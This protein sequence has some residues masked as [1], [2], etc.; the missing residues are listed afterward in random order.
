MFDKFEK[1]DAL[2]EKYNE[3]VE[4]DNYQ[5][6]SDGSDA[7]KAARK[8]ML[9]SSCCR[10][11]FVDDV[12]P[13]DKYTFGFI[14]RSDTGRTKLS[15]RPELVALTSDTTA[16]KDINLLPAEVRHLQVRFLDNLERWKRGDINTFSEA[17]PEGCV[18]YELD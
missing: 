13:W 7:Q 8:A 16:C 6:K 11:R 3:G 1:F 12:E 17:I 10:F 18:E 4:V 5:I 14:L 2:L 9:E 15:I